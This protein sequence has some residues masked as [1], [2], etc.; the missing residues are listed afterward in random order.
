MAHMLKQM[1]EK[2]SNSIK[3]DLMEKRITI[4]EVS[5][6]IKKELTS[7]LADLTEHKKIQLRFVE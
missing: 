2:G 4:K 7:T 3:D 6:I 1:L 5:L